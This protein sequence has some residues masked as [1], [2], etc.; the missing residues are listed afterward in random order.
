MFSLMRYECS[1]ANQLASMENDQTQT[2][3]EKKNSLNL[4]AISISFSNKM[5]GKVGDR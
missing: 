1:S 2:L 4:C 5:R 3:K